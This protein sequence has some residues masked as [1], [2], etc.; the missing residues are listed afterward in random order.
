MTIVPWLRSPTPL[1][2]GH[3]SARIR[4]CCLEM[5]YIQLQM[6]LPNKTKTASHSTCVMQRSKRYM[7]C[8]EASAALSAADGMV[9]SSHQ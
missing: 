4:S 9:G 8:R 5:L 6:S 7:S 1:S 2:L 3:S